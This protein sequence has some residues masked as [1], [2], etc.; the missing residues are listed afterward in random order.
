[1]VGLQFL[2]FSLID[3]HVFGKEL[4]FVDWVFRFFLQKALRR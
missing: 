2:D 3:V 4:L 1:M